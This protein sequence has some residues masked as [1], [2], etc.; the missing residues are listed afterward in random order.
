MIQV[1]HL[2]RNFEYYTKATGLK[3]SVKNLFHREKLI[4]EAV[5]DVSFCVEKG[6]IIGL[7]GPNGAGKTTTLKMLSG[8]LFPSSG[9]ARVDGFIPWERKDE[10]KRKFSIV[11]GQKNQLWWDLPACDSFYLNKCIF[12]ISDGEYRRT[13]SEL[14]ELLDVKD[15]LNVQVR[16]LSLGERMKMEIL[17]KNKNNWERSVRDRGLEDYKRAKKIDH[18]FYKYPALAEIV[19]I[20]GRQYPENKDDRDDIILKSILR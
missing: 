18:E 8:I 16:R 5:K 3:G 7:L 1:E 12:D 15:L 11:M 13:I 9:S 20:I 17:N 19:R 14:S 10:F 6:E 2:T 4:K